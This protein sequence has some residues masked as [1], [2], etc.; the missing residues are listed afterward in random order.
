M[1]LRV[2]FSVTNSFE[3]SSREIISPFALVPT[4]SRLRTLTDLLSSSS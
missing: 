2:S 1:R 3:A 4:S